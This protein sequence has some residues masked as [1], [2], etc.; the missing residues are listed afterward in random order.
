MA[1]PL[2]S[3]LAGNLRLRR[4]LA[5]VAVQIQAEELSIQYQMVGSFLEV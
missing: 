2:E 4:S 5:E 3:Q 1:Y